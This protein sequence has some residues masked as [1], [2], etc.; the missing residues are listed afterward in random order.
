MELVKRLPANAVIVAFEGPD[1]AS[2][3]GGL[4]VR[5]SQL[6]AA[7]GREG[8]KTHLYFVGD[9]ALSRVEQA[10]AN[11]TLHRRCGQIASALHGGVYDRED[12][13]IDEFVRSVPGEIVDEIVAPA[14][15][16]G[17]QTL[18]IGEDWQIA[19]TVI[20][21]DATLRE[22]GM[23]GAALL[24]WN[25][26]NTYGFDRVD[27]SAL[28]GA[29]QITAVSRFMKFEL[30][31][32]GATAMVIPNGIP[33]ELPG[34]FDERAV[35]T[36]RR[37]MRGRYVLLKVGRYDADKR[38][39]Q[40][41]DAVAELHAAGTKV[42]LVVRGGKEPYGETVL[43]RAREH[44]LRIAEI[45]PNESTPEELARALEE[46]AGADVVD[47]RRFVPDETLYALYG[48]VEAVLANS[49]KEPFG[50]VGLEVMA[51]RGIPVCG[52]TGEE[53][54]RPFDNAIVCDTDDPR[55]LA[56]YL[57]LLFADP[58]L[59][60]S[61]RK[62]AKQTAKRYTWPMMLDTLAAKVSFLQ[63]GAAFGVTR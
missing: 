40:V 2:M 9:P 39:M 60:R 6:A 57:R 12:L 35:K 7:L 32:A 42:Q 8:V 1:R 58:R 44:A 53:Y 49:G 34:S 16:R 20:R 31:R 54:A 37:A 15:E 18:V 4:G 56:A 26:N 47:I 23:R 33:A 63:D 38:W 61:I 41:I 45:A 27:W 36:L 55:E 21:L 22:R 17:E 5:V 25:A 51:M 43:Q 48:A 24:M 46:N 62:A 52:S 29:A 11:V 14:R 3:V 30:A 59:A 28:A 10:A 13:K 50:L 19:P